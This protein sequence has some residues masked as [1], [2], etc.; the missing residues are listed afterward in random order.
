MAT[1]KKDGGY[2]A[3]PISYKRGN[4]IPLDK[5]AVWYDKAEMEAYAASNPIAY[6]GQILSYVD[7]IND[8]TE[9]YVIL[10]EAGNLQ[11]LDPKELQDIIGAAAGDG[12]PATG[13]YADLEKKADKDN[14][15]TKTEVDK[16]IGEIVVEGA[17]LKRVIIDETPSDE[18]PLTSLIDVDDVDALNTIYMVK[19]GLNN[20]SDKYNEY[21]VLVDKEGSRF[22]EPVGSWE[23][24]LDNYVTKEE[25]LKIPIDGERNV[26]NSINTAE[27]DIIDNEIVDRQLQINKISHK[28]V[29]GLED[30]LKE[31]RNT[32]D[33]IPTE[34][35]LGLDDWLTAN[36][37]TLIKNI[38]VGNL[39]EALQTKIN[40]SIS[41]VNEAQFSVVNGVLNLKS[42]NEIGVTLADFNKVVGDLNT[43]LTN[44]YNVYNEI[45]S[46]KGILTWQ[47]INS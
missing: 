44:D 17:H 33:K 34:D 23:V 3:L 42:S 11:R 10:D 27:F 22:I 32:S 12:T 39:D 43:L 36:G 40:S 5:S 37:S 6:V 46:I 14:V 45:E 25:F 13:L 20:D 38:G 4:P 47:N 1:I 31:K 2:N 26:I 15:Y 9:V 35:I 30:L 24:N 8:N 16:K 19:T 28:K 18:K 21:I 7:E 41:Q 29:E